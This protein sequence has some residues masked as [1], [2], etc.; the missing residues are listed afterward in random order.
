MRAGVLQ[1]DPALSQCRTAHCFALFACI[2]FFCAVHISP[3]HGK[4]R[5]D[6]SWIILQV[7]EEM[8]TFRTDSRNGRLMMVSLTPYEDRGS[9]MSSF[10]LARV[11][12]Q[13]H[14]P[15]AVCIVVHKGGVNALYNNSQAGRGYSTSHGEQIYREAASVPQ[16]A[17]RAV[18]QPPHAAHE[19]L[20]K[21]ASIAIKKMDDDFGLS[22]PVIVIGYNVLGR[23]ASIRSSKRCITHIIVGDQKARSKGDL[24]QLAFSGNGDT[25]E[26][27]RLAFLKA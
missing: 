19:K 15:D 14:V 20:A 10:G 17:G 22:R 24:E 7:A 25:R 13:E 11:I 4:C 3:V 21:Q 12:L 16:A 8:L 26:V 27:S 23:C 1:T 5:I 9:A 6:S 2:L 18:P